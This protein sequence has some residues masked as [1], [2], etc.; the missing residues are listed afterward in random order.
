MSE[1][2]DFA[3]IGAGIAGASAAYRLAQHG[4]VAVFEMEA[5]ADYHSTGRSAAL[6]TECD[7]PRP[8]RRLAMAS[9]GFL[10]DPPEGFSDS[11]ILHER[12]VMFIGEAGQEE[13]VQAFYGE[14]SPLVPNIILLEPSEVVAACD[15]L[16]EECV[17]AAVFEPDAMDI[18]VHML[19]S[20]FLRGLRR[21]GGRLAT[22]SPVTG[23]QKLSRTWRV[24][25]GATTIEA[26]IVVNAAGA[27]CDQVAVMA[28]AE[29]V[30][31][32]PKRRTAFT[33]AAP[34]GSH[35]DE[36]PMIVDAAAQFYFRPEG[37]S[38]LGSPMDRTAVEPQD[39]RHE[40]VDV[41]MAIERIE[42]VTKL[43]I[44]HVRSAWAGL[45]SFVADNVPVVGMDPDLEG[46]FW[47]GGQGGYGIMTSPAM[48]LITESLIT[49]GKFP[50][51]VLEHGVSEPDL[52]P[53][54]L[55]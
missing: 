24:T 49:T 16:R 41:A 15:T 32:V 33:F 7:G 21:R 4:S 34:S 35:H 46:F 1:N 54:R 17:S 29:L 3:V 38:L 13:M 43:E 48:S 9:K 40:E 14:R 50:D 55:R 12:G 47:L 20:G 11:P 39:I 51:D 53:A 36:W 25:A 27:W 5:T 30:G 37:P 22:R 28:G 8:L 19:H 6:Y 18:D 23:L 10:L 44:R 2:V 52:S 31:L 42:A 26:A 45:R